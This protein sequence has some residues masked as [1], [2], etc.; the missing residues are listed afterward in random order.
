MDCIFQ[1]FTKSR[2]CE[3]IKPPE[4]NVCSKFF[5][6]GIDDEFLDWHH[7]ERDKQEQST[8]RLHQTKSFC[9]AK[10]YHK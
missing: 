9:T 6:I 3:T 1:V 4:E 5:N 7:V 8:S 2:A 10:K